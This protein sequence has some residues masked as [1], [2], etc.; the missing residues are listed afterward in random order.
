M[1]KKID[2]VFINPN[3]SNQ[4]YQKLSL[5]YA[6]VEPPTWSLLLAQ[7][8][9]SKG[10]HVDIIDA[11]AENL[12]DTEVFNRLKKLDPKYV[13][14]V[15]YGQNVNSGTTN[16]AGATKTSKYL[17]SKN[18]NKKIIFIG[19]HVQAL[20]I[21]TIKNERS[22]DIICTNEGVYTLHNLLKLDDLSEQS[23]KDV[24]GIIF[25]DKNKNVIF[26]EAE[27]IVPQENMDIDLPG[28]AWDL[29]PYKEK[30]FDLYRSP[31]WH[32]GYVDENR[33]PYAAIQTSLGCQ[34]KCDFCMINIINRHDNDEV[35]VASNYN[36][37]RYW[38]TEFIIKEFDK[39][40][41]YGVKT[42]KITD[43]MFLLNPKY[44]LPLCK[45]LKERNQNND[46]RI[47]A[48][49]RIDTVKRTEVL[50]IVK[51]AGIKW[52][53]LGIESADKTIRLEISKGKFEDVDV[54]KVV[55]QIHEAG[56]EV[57]ANYIYGL[58]GDNAE[59]MKKTLELSID[60]CTSGWNSY[61]AMALPG[62]SLYKQAKDKGLELP[63]TYSAYSFHS[64]ETLPLS[65]EFLS[66]KDI[67]MFRDNAFVKYHKN[68]TFLSRIEN[69]FG[70]NAVENINEM[71]KVKL[72]RKIFN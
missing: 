66:A 11:N 64:Y 56:I 26:N 31:M 32:A 35:G 70:K 65:N 50:Q 33:S 41:S 22:I 12:T 52:L 37:M 46:L 21:E 72:D 28:Y 48:Y 10:F 36:K 68:K 71:L 1:T 7:S 40:L 18:L 43:E 62:S 6:A 25:I 19:S 15:V 17:K 3:N 54:K 67:L 14:L 69:I 57:M 39:L 4:V 24:K 45:L 29:L 53:C 23:L 30:P 5:K 27:R 13:C 20:P 34:F 51:D 49:S 44:Y 55:E 59:S 38:S 16:M 60:L 47:W 42:I 58:P 63:K 9:R 2:I 61:A 8:C